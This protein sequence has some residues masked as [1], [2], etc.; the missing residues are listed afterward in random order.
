MGSFRIGQQK[1]KISV[2]DALGQD[3]QDVP[4]FVCHIGMSSKNVEVN[5]QQAV[6]A[7]MVEMCPPLV[8]PEVDEEPDPET[9]QVDV[10]GSVELTA[11]E[12]KQISV[13]VDEIA[14]ELESVPD[15]LQYWVYP[16]FLDRINPDS[17]RRYSCV[18]FVQQ[19]YEYAEIDLVDIESLPNVDL[20]KILPAY[21]D[22]RELLLHRRARARV[23]LE[24]DGPWP[25]LLPGY[26]F[27]AMNRS[28]LECRSTPYKPQA[29]DECFPRRE[30]EQAV[31][32]ES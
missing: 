10:V 1:S 13:F 30:K 11:S 3:A 16:H 4:S 2:Y 25:V 7:K 12:S 21:P 20:E 18:G 6:S 5:G 26:V 27:H 22:R 31:L 29:G 17:S 15:G 24:G 32:V 23:G 28:P 8:V 9:D 19:A 14:K